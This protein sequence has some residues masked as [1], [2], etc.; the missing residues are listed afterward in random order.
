MYSSSRIFF[1]LKLN[2]SISGVWNEKIS[3]DSYFANLAQQLFS[4]LH[5]LVL[6][7]NPYTQNIS[8][9]CHGTDIESFTAYIH[10][11]H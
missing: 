4:S 5:K 6:N 3:H 1:Y 11:K 7:N 8:N 10:K 2:L 9:I